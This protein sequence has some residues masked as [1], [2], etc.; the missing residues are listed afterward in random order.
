MSDNETAGLPQILVGLAEMASKWVKDGYG[1]GERL[2][3]VVSLSWSDKL[4]VVW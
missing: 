4:E 3:M 1:V 2:K